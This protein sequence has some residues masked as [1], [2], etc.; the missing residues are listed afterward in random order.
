MESLL[1]NNKY[2]GWIL[3][4]MARAKKLLL[5]STLLLLLLTTSLTARSQ[6][7]RINLNYKKTTLGNVLRD[8]GN[9]ASMLVVYSN[10]DVNPSNLVSISAKDEPLESVLHKLLKGTN[11]TFSIEENHI[12]LSQKSVR[13]PLADQAGKYVVKGNVKDPKG[14]NLIGVNI[15]IRGTSWGTTTDVN[16]NFS[17]PASADDILNIS[18][19]GFIPQSIPVKNVT[20]INV[21]LNE[22]FKKINEVVI[23]ALGIK[24]KQNALSYNIQEIGSEV[25]T[26]AKDPNF[27]NSLTSKIAGV[28]INSSSAGIGGATKVLMRGP[29]SINGNNNALYVVD[30]IP[31]L[32]T[33]NGETLGEY[34]SQPRGEGISD[35][36]PEDIESIS[37]LTGA[38]AAALYGSSAA[39]GVIIITTKTG[40]AGNTHLTISNNTDFMT[41]FIM[42]RFQNTYGNNEGIYASWGQKLNTKSEYNPKDFFNTGVNV[43]NSVSLSIGNAKNQTYI[44]LATTNSTGII[45]NNKYNRYNFTYRNSSSFLEGKMLFDIGLSYIMQNDRNMM[46][47]G[48]YFNP[49]TAIYTFPRSDSFKEVQYYERFNSDRNIYVQY[50]PYGDQG[51][52]MQNPY[53]VVN[54][55]IYENKKTRYMLNA[56]LK[57]LANSWLNITGRIRV[58]NAENKYTKKYYAST[59][60]LF[61]GPKGFYM[62][63]N[64]DDRQ[65]YADAIANINKSSKEFSLSTNIGTSVSYNKLKMFG[66]QGPLKDVPN[67]FSA[68]NVDIQ[69]RDSKI[70]DKIGPSNIMTPSIFTNAELGWR[71]MAFVT[72][73]G[74]NDWSSTLVN[75]PKKSFFYPSVGFSMLLN[76]MVT[77]PKSISYLK[78]RASWASVG[79]AIPPYISIP[80]YQ[81][82]NSTGQWKTTTYMPIDRLYPER[83]NSWEVGFNSTLFENIVSLDFTLY[84]SNTTKQTFNMPICTSS[85]YDSWYVQTG[86]VE[87]RGIELTLKVKKSWDDLSWSSGIVYS[88]NKNEIVKLFDTNLID[89]TGAPVRIDKISKGGIGSSDIILTEGGT[90]GDL[91]TKTELKK[92]NKGNIVVDADG[93]LS[94]DANVIRKVGTSLPKCN[95]GYNNEFSWKRFDL[96]FMFSAR[97]GGKVISATQ[98]VLD[99]FGVT[100]ETEVARDNGGVTV[101][102]S[103]FDAQK[104]YE[105]IGRGGVYS[106][107]VYSATNIRMQE[108]RFG[109]TFPSSWFGNKMSINLSFVGR[110]LW[111]LYCKAPFDPEL[112]PSTGTFYQGIDY[113]MQPSLRKVG[114]SLKF[115]L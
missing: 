46:A 114:F 3:V 56:N 68:N 99:G 70:F 26:E 73:T 85:G 13:I 82:D 74:R 76:Q 67:F 40:K 87:N 53:W 8:I 47:Q 24:R 4:I 115:Q 1:S 59:I 45:P 92:D 72:L 38:A 37:I 112:T 11:L 95:L 89:P 21:I 16:G 20:F 88:Q 14:E 52:N 77:L 61:A 98:A 58:D 5:P 69:G 63:Q 109:Y 64:D 54:R 39:N 55:N 97:F 12:I 15:S 81:K 32:N 42:P 110:N 113:F 18:Y 108:V 50:W 102:N 9:Q 7:I 78:I 29:K 86:N 104:W 66:I 6:T 22:D 48:K 94:V 43:Q 44:S 23:T 83:T 107:Y 111:M 60:G 57:Y 105:T 62:N 100:K 34:S 17:I 33:S 71:S 90:I 10:T 101:N 25:L 2:S 106:H 19:I 36:N 30:G 41:P 75:M 93:N 84:K 103:K 51:L 28:S 27:V 49:L 96:S 35:I 91:Y 79:S 80:T 65:L 31:M